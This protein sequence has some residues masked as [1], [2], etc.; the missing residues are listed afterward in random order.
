M[1]TPAEHLA[2]R[3][4]IEPRRGVCPACHAALIWYQTKAR[5]WEGFEAD[6]ALT[7]DFEPYTPRSG[8][9]EV[10]PE[11]GYIAA[12]RRHSEQCLARMH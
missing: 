11:V 3:L 10:R 12:A 5:R 9:P 4:D 2:V 1:S 6:A 7:P 8:G